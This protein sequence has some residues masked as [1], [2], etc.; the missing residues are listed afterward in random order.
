MGLFNLALGE[1]RGKFAGQE[2]GQAL[3]VANTEQI[4]KFL[5][6]EKNE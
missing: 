1:S 5:L 4:C 2:E 3:V 6:K